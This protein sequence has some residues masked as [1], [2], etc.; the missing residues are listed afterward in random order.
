MG[1]AGPVVHRGGCS[2]RPR[3]GHFLHEG[4]PQRAAV[5]VDQVEAMFDT[6]S[7]EGTNKALPHKVQAIGIR[8]RPHLEALHHQV[9]VSGD[10]DDA[11][12]RAGVVDEILE[13]GRG[14]DGRAFHLVAAGVGGLCDTCQHHGDEAKA[15]RGRGVDLEHGPS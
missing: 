8:H 13:G 2:G 1:L 3:W 12:A 11:G 7:V 15:K 10:A 5:A 9:V 6:E 14:G 4:S